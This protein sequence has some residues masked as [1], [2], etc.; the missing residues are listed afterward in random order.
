MPGSSEKLEMRGIDPRTSGMQSERSTICG[1]FP[2]RKRGAS[3]I[4]SLSFVNVIVE[5]SSFAYRSK[6]GFV[7]AG[8][9]SMCFLHA[10]RLPLRLSWLASGVQRTYLC[11]TDVFDCL[12]STVVFPSTCFWGNSGWFGARIAFSASSVLFQMIPFAY[13]PYI[14][15]AFCFLVQRISWSFRGI[16]PRTSRMLSKLSTM[17]ATSPLWK[18]W[19]NAISNLSFVIAIVGQSLLLHI[20]S[21]LALL[22]RVSNPCVF[23][24]PSACPFDWADSLVGSRGPFDVRG[25]SLIHLSVE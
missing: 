19:A 22:M 18:R 8:H 16:D 9:Q 3:D 25:M 13:W 2:L 20:V 1:T 7:D 23:H 15:I 6:I 5:R 17:W 21:N 24:M 14:S 12:F 10:N 4:W 11:Q